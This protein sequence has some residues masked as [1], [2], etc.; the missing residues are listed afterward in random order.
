MTVTYKK[1]SGFGPDSWEHG[2]S[3]PPGELK[4]S[5]PNESVL[6]APVLLSLSEPHTLFS[7]NSTL[8]PPHHHLL[9][10]S[11]ASFPFL[12][13]SGASSVVTGPHK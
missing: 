13:N 12:P 10:L 6:A 11:A 7:L 9:S 5:A 2:A 3:P 1:I 8:F 4:H